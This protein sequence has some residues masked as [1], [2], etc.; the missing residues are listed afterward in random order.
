M[1]PTELNASAIGSCVRRSVDSY[2]GIV[3]GRTSCEPTPKHIGNTCMSRLVAAATAAN[4]HAWAANLITNQP[5][6]WRVSTGC[7]NQ[8]KR[9]CSFCR[10]GSR[11]GPYFLFASRTTT[12]SC[13]T[14]FAFVLLRSG[15][16]VTA[17]A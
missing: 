7:D 3:L 17:A 5:F 15:F 13:A 12:M 14:D 1:I 11:S 9:T 16:F 10:S 6:Y 4:T 2:I 8:I